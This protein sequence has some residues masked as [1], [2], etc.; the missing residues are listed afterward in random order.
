[1]ATKFGI[2]RNPDF[3]G[4]SVLDRWLATVAVQNQSHGR[5]HADDVAK[6]AAID[7]VTLPLQI[8]ALPVVAVKGY[9]LRAERKVAAERTR[10]E[11]EQINAV[12]ER[13]K[14]NPE[15][16]IEQDFLAR[17]PKSIDNRALNRF[18]IDNRGMH[19]SDEFYYYIYRNSLTARHENTRT[20]MIRNIHVP[21]PILLDAY[22]QHVTLLGTQEYPRWHQSDYAILLRH[23][24]LVDHLLEAALS[25]ESKR[26]RDYARHVVEPKA[27]SNAQTE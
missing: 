21:M 17:D 7:A 12:I 14:A 15:I 24:K 13:L 4:G 27:K 18:V 9:N 3:A 16:C 2:S 10:I 23:P 22:G 1:M 11:N 19:F 20:W 5:A 6:A 25:H 8:L 26:V